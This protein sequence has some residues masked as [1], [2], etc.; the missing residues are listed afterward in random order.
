MN[1]EFKDKMKR[2]LIALKEEILKHLASES[3][4]F[5]GLIDD[6]DPKDLADIASDDIDRQTLE[7]LGAQEIKRLNL[8]DAALSRV[9]DGRYGIC[10]SCGKKIPRERL[11]A[12]PY[13]ILCIECK[14]TEERRN[15]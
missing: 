1:K 15:R 5:Q 14:A 8:I 12:M 2:A 11:G 6:M 9:E 7:A 4:E 10:M 13:A 3:E